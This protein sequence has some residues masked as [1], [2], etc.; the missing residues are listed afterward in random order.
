MAGFVNQ[1]AGVLVGKY[2][3]QR[4]T[5]AK[6]NLAALRL[7][8]LAWRHCSLIGF[9]FLDGDARLLVGI[10]WINTQA[11]APRCVARGIDGGVLAG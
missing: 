4:L 8:E 7:R 10:E 11:L 3:D 1:R 9:A 6:A 2:A 5:V